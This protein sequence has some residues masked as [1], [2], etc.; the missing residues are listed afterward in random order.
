MELKLTWIHGSRSSGKWTKQ[1]RCSNGISAKLRGPY[2]WRVGR[3]RPMPSNKGTRRWIG[4]SERQ[5]T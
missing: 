1:E 3:V 5:A 2:A 4:E